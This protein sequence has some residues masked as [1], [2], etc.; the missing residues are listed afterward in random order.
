MCP[1]KGIRAWYE[2]EEK[3]KTEDEMV[4]WHHQLN[5]HRFGWT[6]GV[7]DG[8]GSLACCDSGGRKK[9][10]TT[11]QLNWTELCGSTG[12]ESAYN[13]GDLGSIPGVGRSPGEGKGYLL[14]YS[15]L[16]NPMNCIV[17]GHKK[18][19][20]TEW[21]SLSLLFICNF[22]HFFFVHLLINRRFVFQKTGVK[23]CFMGFS[24]SG[25]TT[26]IEWL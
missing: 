17:H 12:K 7:G 15:G 6:P 8:Q 3:G 1:W 23:E 18:L 11:K 20:M 4:G 25:V 26:E 22:Y 14:Q 9:L 2:S 10:D 13:A 24:H 16:E 19:D 21:L 5:G